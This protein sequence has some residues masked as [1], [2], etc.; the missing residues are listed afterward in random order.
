MASNTPSPIKCTPPENVSEGIHFDETESA[1]ESEE[2]APE[3]EADFVIV[4]H[5][6][7]DAPV[8][9]TS[10]PLPVIIIIAVVVICAIAVII[11]VMKIKSNKKKA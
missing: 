5:N 2:I 8:A 7:G 3:T 6:K 10:N 1:P 11:M 9:S 4:F